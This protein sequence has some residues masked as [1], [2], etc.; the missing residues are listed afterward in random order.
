MLARLFVLVGGLIVLALTAALVGPYFIDWT[1]YRAE[2]EREAGAILGRKVTVNGDATARLLP[3]PSV[4]F[5][6]VTVGG[7]GEGDAMTIETF[8]MDAELAPFLSGEFKIFDMR[9]V[10]PSGVIAIGEDG[11]VD[12]AMRP[13]APFDAKR[14]SLE[15]LTVTE[16]RVEVRHRLSGRT[17]LLSEINADISARS[18]AGP[19]RL[20]GSMRL[21]GTLTDL[22]ASAGTVDEDATMRLRVRATPRGYPLGVESDGNVAFG[23]AGL[24]YAGTFHVSRADPPP[25][26]AGGAAKPKEPGLRLNGRFRL[27]NASLAIDEARLETGPLDNPY[28]AE[29]TASV[30]FGTEPR[31]A[32][33]ANGAQIRF[34]ETVSGSEGARLTLGERVKALEAALIDLP[35][36]TM[37]GTID[38]DLPA[39]LV[40]D[41]TIRDVRLSAEP[42]EGG[43]TLKSAAATLPGR[44]TL[45]ASG[46]LGAA[47]DFRFTG[48]LLLAVAQPSG[49][50]AWVSKDID[51][52]I[53]RL[54][55]AGF[56]ADVDMTEARQTF[57]NLELILGA[58]KFVGQI[59]ARQPPNVRPSVLLRLNGD[60]LDIDGLSAFAALFVSDGGV[61]RFAETDLDFDIKAGP[62]T[63]AGLSADTLDTALRLRGGSLE[64]DRLSVGGIAGASI[65][66]TGRIKDFPRSPTGNLDASVVAVDLAPL[67]RLAAAQSPGN[68]LLAQLQARVDAHPGLLADSKI[69]FVA[70]AAAN[71]DGSD[72]LAV[73]LQGLAGGTSFSATL[74]GKGEMAAPVDTKL[75]L[76]VSARNEDAGAL[77]SM[78]GLPSVPL[79]LTGAGELALS[80]NGVPAKEM[81]TKFSL[82]G[83]QFSATFDGATSFAEAGPAGHGRLRIDADDIEPWLMTAGVVL[84]GMGMGTAVSLAADA[85][86]DEGLLVLGQISGTIDEEAVAGDIN[87]A[88]KD[89]LPHLS[90]AMTLDAFDVEPAVTMLLGDASVIAEDGS[91]SA[92]PFRAAAALPLTADLDLAVDTLSVGTAA[93][94]YDATL[95]LRLDRQGLRVSEL[96]STLFGGRLSGLFE[97]KNT[98][99]TGILSGQMQLADAELEQLLPG[100][101][102]S[103]RGTVSSTLSGSG[104]SAEGIIATLSGSGTAS[105]ASYTID[106]LNA[107]A[108]PALLAK[109][110]G[111]GRDIDAAKTAA[112]VPEIAGAGQFAG[113]SA[114]MAFTVAG[115][116]VRAQAVSLANPQATLAAD[117]RGDVNSESVSVAATLTYAAGDE[118]LAGSEPALGIAV[119]GPF[120][121]ATKS[122]D[123]QPLAQFLTQRALERE[124][125]RV[126]AMQAALLEKQRLRREVRYYASLE[127]ERD[128]LAEEQR[129]AEEEA[130]RQAEEERLK[131]EEAEKQRLAA[132]KAARE[133]EQKRLAEEAAK[134]EREAK[135]KA[136]Q[137]AKAKAEEEARLAAEAAR[138]A[139]QRRIADEQARDKAEAARVAAEQE[140]RRVAEPVPTPAPAPKRQAAPKPK[141]Q[142]QPQ[143]VE[144]APTTGGPQKKK[145]EPFT[146]DGFLKSLQGG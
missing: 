7:T 128:R 26:Q 67:V 95:S 137:E 2:F 81:E 76:T 52:A 58:A 56:S 12:W 122:F 141:P 25:A 113:S 77:M 123:S 78:M 19:W 89:G 20:D 83:S 79:G 72:G 41:T 71:A 136:E 22:S 64:I 135:A 61:T 46:F 106:G 10:R 144:D 101:G 99:G 65:S 47:D 74:S 35:R 126:E 3:F 59:E 117:I 11:A 124:Q 114:D 51:D 93:S 73:S 5:S 63:V 119:A 102:V 98:T 24:T 138:E 90:G 42:A 143:A 50:A 111:I 1:S 107:A 44:T 31:F 32:I 6:D 134:A 105:L 14:I 80:V 109:A 131:A 115:G 84:P 68:A 82:T 116:V 48:K 4:T 8:S 16:G 139:E 103:G 140:A 40:G 146:I 62:V 87:A 125:A 121:A 28:T 133:A 37:K 86:Y 94:A 54:P 92:A 100:S 96:K 23:K 18:L 91:W 17:H 127:M 13:S 39:V 30:S 75:E 88:M 27:D 36:P 145:V 33:E 57:K 120:G 70:S 142:P 132:E 129:K 45:E 15:K 43:W 9:M 55:A 60:A 49:F 108:F 85:D 66:A 69:D 53:R 118:A 110:D 21:D 29:G 104:K 97:L 112:F 34:D 38:V 130:R